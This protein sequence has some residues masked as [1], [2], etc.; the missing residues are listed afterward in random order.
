LT[1]SSRL[2]R[3]CFNAVTRRASGLARKQ[4]LPVTIT[5]VLNALLDGLNEFTEETLWQH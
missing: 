1:A 2:R 5:L 3:T 4:D